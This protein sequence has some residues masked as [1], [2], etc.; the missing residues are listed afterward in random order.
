MLVILISVA[1][2]VAILV[3]AW[4]AGSKS[5]KRQ[6]EINEGNAQMATFLARVSS[7]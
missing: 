6:V 4:V 5:T 1:I 7:R 3:A 2:V